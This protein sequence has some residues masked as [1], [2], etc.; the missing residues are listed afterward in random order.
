MPSS[1]QT[2]SHVR[3]A[4]SVQDWFAYPKANAMFGT[5]LICIPRYTSAEPRSTSLPST[6]RRIPPNGTILSPVAVTIRSASSSAPD[7]SAMPVSVSVSMRSVTTDTRPSLI[8]S[9]RSPS[10][11]THKRWS[12]GS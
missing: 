3:S 11:T 2:C 9:K 7:A 8:A 5:P 12:H 1:L 4:P 6:L 10:G